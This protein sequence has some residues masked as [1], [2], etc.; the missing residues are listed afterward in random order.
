MSQHEQTTQ[1]RWALLPLKLLAHGA[2]ALALTATIASLVLGPRLA[3][4]TVYYTLQTPQLRDSSVW[5]L[6]GLLL[7]GAM[8]WASGAL[9]WHQR[10]QRQQRG[11]RL[12]KL[13]RGTIMTETIIIMPLF[14]MMTFGMAQLSVNMIGGLLANIA[15]YQAARTVWVWEGEIGKNRS[16][17]QVSESDVL[18]RARVAAALVM[19]PIAPGDYANINAISLDGSEP[20]KNMR[21]AVSYPFGATLSALVGGNIATENTFYE[22]LDASGFHSRGAMKFSVAYMATSIER[23]SGGAKLTYKHYQAFPMVG[24]LF[25]ELEFQGLRTGYYNTYERNVT[26]LT[27]RYSA[28]PVLPNNETSGSSVQSFDPS[29]KVKGGSG[30]GF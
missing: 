22:A 23:L 4:K 20:A 2:G 7:L 12:V 13:S 16:G 25:G 19:T 9:V 11:P 27:Q 14:L 10:G 24:R 30:G 28:N 17:T 15:G 5:E 6:S 29:D 8:L 18:D 26:F 3:Y 21:E 1:A